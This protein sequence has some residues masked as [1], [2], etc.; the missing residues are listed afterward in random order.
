MYIQSALLYSTPEGERRIRVHNA[1]YPLTNIRHLL[2]D[3]ID[4]SAVAAFWAR[5]SLARLSI[6]QFNFSTTTA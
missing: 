3:Y 1:S 5:K 2:F 4:P 6:N